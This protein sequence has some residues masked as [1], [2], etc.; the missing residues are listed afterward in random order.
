MCWLAGQ[1]VSILGQLGEREGGGVRS[2][3]RVVRIGCTAGIEASFRRISLAV[4]CGCG[5]PQGIIR[6]CLDRDWSPFAGLRYGK[7]Q[8]TW[9]REAEIWGLLT[10]IFDIRSLLLACWL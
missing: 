3:C 4:L 8:G 6:V 9:E 10:C 5:Q 1:A 2:R 7:V